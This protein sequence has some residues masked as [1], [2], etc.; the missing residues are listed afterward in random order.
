MLPQ[1]ACVTFTHAVRRDFDYNDPSTWPPP[2]MRAGLTGRGP[3]INPN[4][5]PKPASNGFGGAPSRSAA[6]G[7]TVAKKT[8]AGRK[9]AGKGKKK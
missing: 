1:A 5:A 3:Q 2:E 6:R 7:N 9:G 4:Q 8:G